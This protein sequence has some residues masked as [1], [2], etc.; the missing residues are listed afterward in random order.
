MS[1]ASKKPKRMGRPP[2]PGGRDVLVAGRVPPPVVVVL[3]A[4]AEKTGVSRS[5]A[6]RQLIELGL[7]AKGKAR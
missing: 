3:D 6:V 4:F 5:E 1:L 2:K 7:K